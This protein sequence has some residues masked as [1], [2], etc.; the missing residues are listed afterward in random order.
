MLKR[1]NRR[2]IIITVI[3]AII[4]ICIIF[5]IPF[6]T[7]ELDT[8]E[9]YQDTEIKK[10]PYVATESYVALETHEIENTIYDCTSKSVYSGLSVPFSVTQAD[11][12]LVGSFE[13]PSPG[14]FYVYSSA[15]NEVYEK[16][17]TKGDIDISLPKGEYRALLRERTYAG[18]PLYLNLKVKWAEKAE[19]TKNREVTKYRE[20]TVEVEKQRTVTEYG[21][22]SFWEIIFK[23]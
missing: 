2:I 12:R 10:E 3:A 22:V 17:G 4:L 16:L 18:K 1:N 19:V 5:S 9:T 7:V 11:S 21:K 20:V 6:N 14:D 23:N 15:D 8:I 13:L